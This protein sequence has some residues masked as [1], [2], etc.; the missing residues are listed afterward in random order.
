[1]ARG[2]R[3]KDR[4]GP[5]RRCI[6]TGQSGATDCLIRFVLAPDGN[7]VPDIAGKLPGRGAWLTSDRALIEKA[8][9][10]RLFSRAF[11]QPVETMPDLADRLDEMLAT[12]LIDL[13]SL[14]RKAG[15][16]ITGAE[17]VRARIKEGAAGVLLQASDGAM[18]G[19]AKLSAL[20]RAVGDG[21]ITEVSVLTADELGLAFGREFAIHAALDAGGFAAR[22]RAD[23]VRLSGLRGLQPGEILNE[24]EIERSGSDMD[25]RASGTTIEGPVIG[26]RE[27]DDT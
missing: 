14:A 1:M 20:A 22:V 2:G 8:V 13:I 6:V 26:T 4:D 11:R 16:A 9:K 23:A 7:A 10:K 3:T 17:K 12:R 19:R 27:Q 15:Q 5:E 21:Q 25:A 24:L 18:D